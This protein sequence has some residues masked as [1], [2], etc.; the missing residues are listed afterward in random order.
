MCVSVYLSSPY[1]L[2]VFYLSVYLVLCVL[3]VFVLCVSALLLCVCVAVCMCAC[4]CGVVW[5]CVGG[6]T[7]GAKTA[8]V[9]VLIPIPSRRICTPYLPSIRSAGWVS[10][11]SDQV[12]RADKTGRRGSG[13]TPSS[14]RRSDRHRHR[15]CGLPGTQLR[16]TSQSECRRGLQKQ[17]RSYLHRR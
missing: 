7:N 5:L 3:F 10:L 15:R 1:L 13:R 12:A 8:G 11:R 16:L 17:R 9:C 14:Q 4:M 2:I 6:V